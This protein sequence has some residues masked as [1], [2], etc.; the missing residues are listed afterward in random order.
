MSNYNDYQIPLL[1]TDM[2]I[3]KGCFLDNESTGSHF[4]NTTSLKCTSVKILYCAGSST[5]KRFKALKLELKLPTSS[6]ATMALREIVR[7]DTS[8]LYQST[9]NVE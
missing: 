3:M 2:D 8:S 7:Q 1:A 6:Y 9:L 5:E 4:M